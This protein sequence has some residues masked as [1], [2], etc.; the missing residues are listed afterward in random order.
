M[1]RSVMVPLDGSRFGEQALPLAAAI[2]RQSGAA[3]Q[4]VHKHVPPAPVH[5][6]SVLADD[7]RLDPR[8]RKLE[9]GYLD[10]IVTRLSGDVLGKVSA[11]L[12]DGPL[13]DTLVKHAVES[14][15]DLVVMTT[16]G[17]GPLQRFW[18]GSVADALMRR[19]PMPLLLV[20]PRE[21]D[22]EEPPTDPL[23]RRVL[24]PLDG[25]PHAERI[26]RPALGVGRLAGA[27]YHLLQVVAPVPILGYDMAAYAPAG[28][29]LALTVQLQRQAAAYLE[30]VAGRLRDEGLVV[31]AHAVVGPSAASAILE[32]GRSLQ[33]DLIALETHGRGG[34]GR[35][36]LGSVADKVVRGASVPVLVHR[37]PE[38]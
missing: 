9:R 15:A 11:T 35:L 38:P 14:G 22:E 27:E 19:L 25:S 21:E 12:L 26:L 20:R 6:D 4:L 31:Y 13:A 3:L 18:L 24:V 8:S 5:P 37:S 1:I 28:T 34:L 7:P 30:K 16:H 2:A 36:L 17:R 23:P 33:C 10:A 32:Q 29:D